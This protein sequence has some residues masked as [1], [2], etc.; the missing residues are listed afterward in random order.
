MTNSFSEQIRRR[1]VECGLT[2]AEIAILTKIA[3]PTLS[4]IESSSNKSL[5][6]RS[7]ERLADALSCDLHILLVSR[8]SA[9]VSSF[10]LGLDGENTIGASGMRQ[11][12]PETMLSQDYD[13]VEASTATMEAA[14]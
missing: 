10:K 7:M 13:A 14:S 9:F 4:R 8:D 2:Q 1:R 5:T 11:D 3:Q 6:L 12:V